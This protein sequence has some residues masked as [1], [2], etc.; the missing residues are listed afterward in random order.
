M[1]I[2]MQMILPKIQA[3]EDLKLH[4]LMATLSN[5]SLLKVE[6]AKGTVEHL[7]QSIRLHAPIL[8][9]RENTR[10]LLNEG[11]IQGSDPSHILRLGFSITRVNGQAIKQA[12]EVKAGDEIETILASGT[13]K[14]TITWTKK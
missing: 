11:K 2:R 5:N 9:Q 1:L 13:L 3:R 10:I 4:Q 7:Y 8:I 6:Q 12:T 14:S